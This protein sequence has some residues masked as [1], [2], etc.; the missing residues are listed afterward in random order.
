M[1]FLTVCNKV[2]RKRLFRLPFD[3]LVLSNFPHF[4]SEVN[5]IFVETG[6]SIAVS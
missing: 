6:A 3:Y 1:G 5:Q 4:F 2:H